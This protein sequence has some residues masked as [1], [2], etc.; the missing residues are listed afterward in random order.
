MEEPFNLKRS[1]TSLEEIRTIKQQQQDFRQNE[2]NPIG[3]GPNMKSKEVKVEETQEYESPHR[4]FLQ[5]H[6]LKNLGQTIHKET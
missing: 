4:K 3:T 1:N 6:D 2:R 5:Y